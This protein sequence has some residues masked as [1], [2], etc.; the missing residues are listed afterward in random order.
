MGEFR[1]SLRQGLDPSSVTI[2]SLTDALLTNLRHTA[3]PSTIAYVE[4]ASGYVCDAFGDT[5]AVNLT[6]RDVEALF[7]SLDKQGLSAREHHGRYATPARGAAMKRAMRDR[8]VLRNVV[9]D[10]DPPKAK[11]RQ[12]VLP[13]ADEVSAILG[14][15]KQ[16][17]SLYWPV[18]ALIADTAL[19]T[20]EARG[21]AGCR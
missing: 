18:L 6:A 16:A 11:K 21:I 12:L 2:A 20:G 17:D 9:D 10:V 1:D 8:V 15:L 5:K 19:R 14:A 13:S 3:R 7:A 4:W